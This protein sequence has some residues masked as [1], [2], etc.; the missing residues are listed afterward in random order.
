MSAL[1][2]LL[3]DQMQDMI[4][5]E[6][7][8]VKAYPKM[9]RAARNPKLKQALQKHLEETKNQVDRLK[10]GFEILGERAKGKTCRA[11]EGL[12]AETLEH[13]EEGR[14]KSEPIADL[15]LVS[16][17]QRMEHYEISAYGTARTIAETLGNK[18]LAKLLQQTLAEEEKTD[19]LLTT[20]S[21]P[22][23]QEANQEPE[24]EEEE[25]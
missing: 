5:A 15:A 13:I 14:E 7:Q 25:E 10:Q 6:S 2:E 3:V 9:I 23:L 24:E 20:L 11:M 19:K 22:L 16:V 18:K 4:H 8:A 1:Q 21:P 12:V 17:A